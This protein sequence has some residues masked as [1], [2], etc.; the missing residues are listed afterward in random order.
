MLGERDGGEDQRVPADTKHID[1]R[2]TAGEGAIYVMADAESLQS[3]LANLVSNAIQY[4]PDPGQ[5]EVRAGRDRGRV[6]VEVVD[7]GIGIPEEDLGSIFQEFYRSPNAKEA[8]RIGTGLGLSIV[9]T[10][11]ENHRGQITVESKVNEGSTFT[12]W[13]PEAAS[14]GMAQ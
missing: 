1:L 8:S 3:A 11:I 10:T 4:T 7:S 6:K 9:K 13:L 12:V 2:M 14:E 5:V